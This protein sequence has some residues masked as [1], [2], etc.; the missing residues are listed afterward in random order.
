MVFWIPGFY[1]RGISFHPCSMQ[2]ER[3]AYILYAS[4]ATFWLFPLE[5][6]SMALILQRVH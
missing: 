4:K 1:A 2:K 6:P 5:S 3:W